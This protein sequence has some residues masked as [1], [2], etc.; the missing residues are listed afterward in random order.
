MFVHFFFALFPCFWWEKSKKTKQKYAKHY[1]IVNAIRVLIFVVSMCV[2]RMF[3][4]C[5]LEKLHTSSQARK[6]TFKNTVWFFWMRKSFCCFTTINKTQTKKYRS[7]KIKKIS[8]WQEQ[9]WFQTTI[10]IHWH[11]SFCGVLTLL[12]N[13]GFDT[14]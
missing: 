9:N 13:Q 12:P 8:I 14:S 5:F 6:Q 1:G 7:F 2:Y 10:H 11:H 3:F 4:V